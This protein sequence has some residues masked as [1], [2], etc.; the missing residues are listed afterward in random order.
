MTF[1][2]PPPVSAL[3][4]FMF[5]VHKEEECISQNIKNVNP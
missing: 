1:R 3:T 5:L 2:L 4:L